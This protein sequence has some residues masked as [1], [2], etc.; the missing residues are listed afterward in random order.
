MCVTL[1]SA[2]LTNITLWRSQNAEKITHIKGRLLYQAFSTVMSLFKLELLKEFQ[3]ERILSSKSSS[4][5]YGK[6]LL[7]PL[8]VTISITYVRILRNGS[9]TNATPQWILFKYDS[10]NHDRYINLCYIANGWYWC[11]SL[12]CC[13]QDMLEIRYQR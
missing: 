9:N 13:F 10:D 12:C 8:S 7:A 1:F 2:S 4:W 11:L 6:S 3:R 5:W